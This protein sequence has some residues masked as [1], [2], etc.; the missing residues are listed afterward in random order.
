[1]NYRGYLVFMK[2][3]FSKGSLFRI[4]HKVCYSQKPKLG[5]GLGIGIGLGLRL[6]LGLQKPYPLFGIK[7]LRNNEPS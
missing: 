5:L 3:C 2:V 4:E 1:M 6:G 7:N